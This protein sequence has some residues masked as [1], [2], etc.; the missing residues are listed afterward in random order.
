MRRHAEAQVLATGEPRGDEILQDFVLRVQPHTAADEV[1]EVD[2]VS[3]AGEAELDAVVAVSQ[4]AGAAERAERVEHLD[5]AL[6]EDACPDR[7]LD[8]FTGTLIDDD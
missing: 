7:G 1:G 5:G 6:F 2:A 3:A 4:G 8:L